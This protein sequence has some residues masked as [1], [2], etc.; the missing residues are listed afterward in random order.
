MNEL[1][2]TEFLEIDPDE[3]FM[4]ATGAVVTLADAGSSFDYA[5]VLA[6]VGDPPAFGSDVDEL[7]QSVM[8]AA[9]TSGLIKP[10]DEPAVHVADDG[11][12]LKRWI[13]T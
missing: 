13:G 6:I 12:E 4:F 10:V 8:R 9:W 5:D 2:D 11:R 1:P 7:P 3:W